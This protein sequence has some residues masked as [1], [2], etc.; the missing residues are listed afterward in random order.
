MARLDRGQ[1]PLQ[2][3]RR[4][5]RTFGAGL[6][7]HFQ[8]ICKGSDAHVLACVSSDAAEPFP[9][10]AGD[11]ASGRDTHLK[12]RL[13]AHNCWWGHHGIADA[14]FRMKGGTPRAADDL[15]PQRPNKLVARATKV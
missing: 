12:R 10:L 6:Q 11:P 8:K 13:H 3:P 15:A 7:V 14:A 2:T 9:W 5:L 4:A 1:P